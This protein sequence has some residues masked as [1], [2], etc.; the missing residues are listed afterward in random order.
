GLADLAVPVALGLAGLDVGGAALVVAG[1]VVVAEQPF[2]LAQVGVPASGQTRAEAFGA[3]ILGEAGEEYAAGEVVVTELADPVLVAVAVVEVGCP[4]V[5]QALFQGDA[6]YLS[7]TVVVTAGVDCDAAFAVLALL[8]GGEIARVEQLVVHCLVFV[9]HMTVA[10]VVAQACEGAAVVGV[11]VVAVAVAVAR[12]AAGVD[13]ES[14][15]QGL[16]DM[17]AIGFQVMAATAGLEIGLACVRRAGDDIDHAADR[18]VAIEYGAGT[19]D[20]LDA[21]DIAQW[22][23]VEV[24]ACQRRLVE[25]ATVHQY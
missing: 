8:F 6:M 19:A 13:R 3:Q 1:D 5:R 2:S 25:A 17:A 12:L 14:G 16:E 7:L 20:D 10:M 24:G 22:H 11:V 18:L 9:E 23:A 4:G 21:L 15:T